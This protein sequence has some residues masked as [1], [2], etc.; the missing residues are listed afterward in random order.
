MGLPTCEVSYTCGLEG[1]HCEQVAVEARR[2]GSGVSAVHGNLL[3]L[4]PALQQYLTVQP[5]AI[6]SCFT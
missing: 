6:L 4:D 1:V 3:K 5:S 2:N